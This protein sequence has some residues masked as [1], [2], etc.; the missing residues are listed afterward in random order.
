MNLMGSISNNSSGYSLFISPS[1]PFPAIRARAGRNCR[2]H[3]TKCILESDLDSGVVTVHIEDQF[4]SEGLHLESLFD[5]QVRIYTFYDT[6]RDTWEAWYN[7]AVKIC[8]AEPERVHRI[9]QDFSNRRNAFTLA[10]RVF[11]SRFS[12]QYGHVPGYAAIVL[13]GTAFSRIA[14]GFIVRE[15]SRWYRNQE[16]RVFYNRDE[17]L[18]WLETTLKRGD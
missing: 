12:Q 18:A 1:A 11:I 5:E 9:I 15:A 3:T 8:D 13:Q 17:A 10:A 6:S 14:Q 7:I 16:I 2:S 4:L